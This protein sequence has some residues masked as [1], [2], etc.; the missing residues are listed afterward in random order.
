MKSGVGVKDASYPGGY[1]WIVP[2][3]YRGSS[4]Y[5]QLGINPETNVIYHF[6]FVR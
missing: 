6:N 5:W 4:G 1:N 2:G 3:S